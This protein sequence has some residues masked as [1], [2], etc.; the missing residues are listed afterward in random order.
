[1][2]SNKVYDFYYSHK[3]SKYEI[4]KRYFKNRSFNHA[5]EHGKSAD[6]IEWDD[7]IKVGTG[8]YDDVKIIDY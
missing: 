4:T 2:T 8:I 7:L 6:H 5:V 3:C 1:M